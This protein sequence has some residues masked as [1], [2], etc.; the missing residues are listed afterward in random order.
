MKRLPPTAAIAAAFLMW[1]E[2]VLAPAA[3]SA[4]E[5]RGLWVDTF[6]PALRNETEARQ[7]VADARRGG[8]N[9]LFVEVRKR[10]DAY[11]DSRFEPRA[12]DVGPGF[13]PLQRLLGL[14]HDITAGPRLEV[15]AWIVAFNI[16]NQ[17]TVLPPQVNHPYR[18]HPEWLTRDSAGN[19]WDGANYAFDPG[20]PGV[21]Q[22]TFNVAMDLVSR[23]DIDGLHWD[24]IRYAGQQWGYNDVAVQRFNARFNRTGRPAT[25]DAAWRQ[26]R[27]DQVSALVRKVYLTAFVLKPHLKIS[28]ATITFAPG[29][30]TTAQWPTSAAYSDVLQDWRAWMEEGILDFN[31][32]MVYFRQREHAEAFGRWNTFI[33]DHQ[34]RRRAAIG[35]AFYLNPLAHTLQQIDL[36]RRPSPRGASAVGVLAYSYANL[37]TD[38]AASQ[39]LTALTEPSTSRPLPPFD[40]PADPV[41]APWKLSPLTGHLKGFIT[42]SSDASPIDGA[43]VTVCGSAELNLTTDATGFFGAVDLPT[44]GYQVRISAPGFEPL[45]ADVDIGGAE[46]AHLEFPVTA[47][48]PANPGDVRASAGARSAVISWTSPL[49]TQGWIELRAF[50]PCATPRRLHDAASET[51][52]SVHLDGLEANTS[53]TFTVTSRATPQ[54][55]TSNETADPDAV[56]TSETRVFRTSGAIDDDLPRPDRLPAWWATHFLGIPTALPDDDTDG[57]GL[58]H[59]EEYCVGTDPTVADSSLKVGLV[60]TLAGGWQ[61]TF[62]PRLETRTYR[63]Q[64]R[65]DT[66]EPWQDL[67]ETAQ[68]DGHGGGFFDAAGTR[69]GRG[70]FRIMVPWPSR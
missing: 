18:L 25:T 7:L 23:Y 39:V 41:A 58:S 21:Q 47:V 11:Y 52:H 66:A 14:A 42:R 35:L 30:T 36:A 16:W 22:H 54:E 59:A 27:R 33:K 13:D 67:E 2:A 55:V 43:T 28:A 38:Q 19:R 17:R 24:Y 40:T 6:H 4:E 48:D 10:G 64:H 29:I 56:W 60:P 9:A 37:A 5:L 62:H 1:L 53:Y 45:A 26:F 65:T 57:D 20:H 63:L 51:Q 69:T 12:T 68:P 15:H 34:Y 3:H 31:L 44:G 61:I 70:Q 8:F 49:P 32:P 50:S 46:V